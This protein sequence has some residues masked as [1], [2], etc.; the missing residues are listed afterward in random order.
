[1]KIGKPLWPGL[2]SET[3]AELLVSSSHWGFRPMATNSYQ[4]TDKEGY[5]NR[6]ISQHRT[7]FLHTWFSFSS[8]V[9][10]P[11]KCLNIHQN[12]WHQTGHWDLLSIC[13]FI[14]NNIS[15][16]IFSLRTT[17]ADVLL[18]FAQCLSSR[19]W[20]ASILEWFKIK[21]WVVLQLHSTWFFWVSDCPKKLW[22][23]N[24]S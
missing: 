4:S 18:K 19:S 7:G 16:E 12:T 14:L 9:L 2:I 5:M 17:F 23:N 13:V 1:M 24:W 22:I 21:L 6:P 15:F 11:D 10:R 20:W 3:L 8:Q